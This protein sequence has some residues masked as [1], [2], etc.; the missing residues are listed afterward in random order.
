VL[1]CALAAGGAANLVK[2]LVVR[3]RP[4]DLSPWFHGS[5]WKTFDFEHWL[6]LINHTSASQSFPSGHT[7]VA[8]GLAAAM[9]WAYPQGRRVFVALAVLVGCQRIVSGAHFPS[10]VLAA[11]AVGCLASSLLLKIGPLPRRLDQLES[12]WRRKKL[13]KDQDIPP[14]KPSSDGA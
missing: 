3:T 11:A 1:L 13:R 5:V 6:P 12:R 14:R 9:I 4:N 2:L 8:A 10:D 7:A